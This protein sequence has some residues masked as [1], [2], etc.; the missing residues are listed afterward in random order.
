MAIARDI[1]RPIAETVR[2]D[3]TIKEVAESMLRTGLP[4]AVIVDEAGRVAGVVLLDDLVI[5]GSRPAHLVPELAQESVYEVMERFGEESK[6]AAALTAAAIMRT[7]LPL[8][9]EDTPTVEIANSMADARVDLIPVVRDGKPIG[10]VT[11]LDLLRSI[12]WPA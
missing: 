12:E 11:K 9:T 5:R 6:A 1:M 8:T 10:V 3:A 7:D 2:R 4:G